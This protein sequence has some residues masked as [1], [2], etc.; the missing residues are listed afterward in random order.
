MLKLFQIL[1]TLWNKISFRLSDTNISKGW[2]II[3]NIAAGVF[4]IGSLLGNPATCPFVIGTVALK[5]I[6]LITVTSGVIAG[7]AQL[8][9]SKK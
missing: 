2:K 8:D 5:W 3:R 7:R 4:A 1:T 9:T 6:G